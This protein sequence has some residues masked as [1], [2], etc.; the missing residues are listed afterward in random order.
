MTKNPW[1]KDPVIL[2]AI[3]SGLFLVAAAIIGAYLGREDANNTAPMTSQNVT[4][5]TDNAE[6]HSEVSA[7]PTPEEIEKELSGVDILPY[8]LKEYKNR[9][10]HLSLTSIQQEDLYAPL[11][12]R[13]VIWE[14]LIDYIIEREDG[15][16]VISI[17]AL[18]DKDAGAAIEFRKKDREKLLLLNKGQKIRV[19]GEI[20]NPDVPRVIN[21]KILR[22]WD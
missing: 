19:S 12:G 21:A 11:V 15:S 3:I 7:I 18:D 4:P 10:Y 22:V 20:I 5:A 6:K 1:H 16:L 9:F 13:K 17:D 2:G 14:G 8:T